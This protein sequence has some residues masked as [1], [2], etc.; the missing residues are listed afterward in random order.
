MDKYYD[1][2]ELAKVFSVKPNTILVWAR[3]NQI[4]HYK[5][6]GAVRFRRDEIEQWVK[7]KRRV[8]AA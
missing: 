1:C 6:N 8:V 4:P 7:S 2:N 5:L 3:R